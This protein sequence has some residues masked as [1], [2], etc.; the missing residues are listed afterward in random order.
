MGQHRTH[1]IQMCSLNRSQTETG[2][3][4]R[5]HLTRQR[6]Q[7]DVPRERAVAISHH[8]CTDHTEKERRK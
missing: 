5:E 6:R 3:V 2:N 8:I 7:S 1:V 4:G